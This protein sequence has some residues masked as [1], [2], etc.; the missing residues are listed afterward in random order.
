M[1]SQPLRIAATQTQ[2]GKAFEYAILCEFA[3][4]LLVY[5]SVQI[6]TDNAY[7]NAKSCYESCTEKEKGLFSIAGSFAVNFLQDLEPRLSN[8]LSKNDQI[9]LQILNDSHGIEGDVRDVLVIRQRQEWE[10]GISA[11]NN[12]EALK[13][14]RISQNIDFGSKWLGIPCS[15]MY[16][17]E[18][19]P[20]F[21]LLNKLKSEQVKWSDM[22]TKSEKVYKPL[23]LAFSNE[24]KRIVNAGGKA[25]ARRLAEY[26]IGTRDFYKVIKRPR[27]V[28]IHAYNLRGDLGLPF[29]DKRSKLEV[30]LVPLPTKIIRVDLVNCPK[31]NQ[32]RVLMDFG[33]AIKMRIHSA[34]T[35]VEASLKFDVQLDSHPSELFKNELIYAK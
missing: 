17:A 24:L 30:P 22:D 23:M 18:I 29:N 20:V 31:M 34:K 1:S 5:S 21:E 19:T 7:L 6:I 12:H 16:F 8:N 27:G 25:A 2:N 35:M 10:I 32:V 26:L 9:E 33:W 13:H 14:S 4:K 3:N 15:D 28:D 11:K